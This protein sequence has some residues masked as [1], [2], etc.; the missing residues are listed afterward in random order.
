MNPQLL[1]FYNKRQEPNRSC[2][3][4]LREIILRHS[5]EI[6]EHLKYGTAYFYYKKKPLCYFWK[7]KTTE[8]PYIGFS[9]GSD[10]EHPLLY[11][12]NRKKMKL[13]Y[14]SATEDIPIN[15]IQELLNLFIALY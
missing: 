8:I 15:K 5:P 12:G 1:S 2:F 11:K 9:R 7:D 14:I 4:A 6:T 3:F 13:Y 10:I